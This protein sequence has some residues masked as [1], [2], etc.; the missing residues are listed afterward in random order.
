MS[1]DQLSHLARELR[2]ALAEKAERLRPFPAFL[3]MATIHAIELEPDERVP[4]DRGCVVVTPE[5]AICGLEVVGFLGAEGGVG[6]EFIEELTELELPVEEY[7]IYARE[8]IKLLDAALGP[9]GE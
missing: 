5:G 4:V 2:Q 9:V 6:E 8:A 3:G 1:H 7:L